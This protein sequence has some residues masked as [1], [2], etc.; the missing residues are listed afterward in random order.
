MDQKLQVM[1][2]APEKTQ[3][4]SKHVSLRD[5]P[6]ALKPRER[7]QAS[8]VQGLSHVELLA[9]LLGTG[10]QSMTALDLAQEMLKRLPGDDLAEL[11]H[12]SLEQLQRLPGMGLAKA[13]RILAAIELGKRV[14]LSDLPERPSL[15]SPQA[16]YALLRPR[17]AHQKQE[18]F[19]ALYLDTKHKLLGQQVI[20]RGLLDGTL[21]HPREIF[22]E[23][24]AYGAYAFV[25]AHNHPSGDPAPS[26]ADLETTRQ[27]IRCGTLMQIELMD[28]VIL[29]RSGYYSLRER[30]NWLW[31]KH[32]ILE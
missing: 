15:S 14:A 24:L 29:G 6:A 23:A 21:I 12:L 17:F 27:L 26:Q 2:M 19:I 3:S 1:Q 5:Y 18:H 25:V 28:H 8:G 13:S 20:T 30:E 22:R 7:M 32:D 10:S 11:G 31:N 9:I 4:L 16:I